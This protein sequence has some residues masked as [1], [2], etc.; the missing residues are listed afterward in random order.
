MSESD[1]PAYGAQKIGGYAVFYDITFFHF[2]HNS[3]ITFTGRKRILFASWKG[4]DC[5][6]ISKHVEAFGI[7]E[8]NS[9]REFSS[10]EHDFRE[11]W[12]FEGYRICI[13]GIR[14]LKNSKTGWA[15]NF[16]CLLII[17]KVQFN[18]TKKVDFFWFLFEWTQTR[19]KNCVVRAVVNNSASD[20]LTFNWI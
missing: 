14:N 16:L 7:D 5:W 20:T 19:W 6:D 18:W 12:S 9:A 15:F 10:F 1:I 11:S 13:W 17:L 4:A 8:G 2:F 3:T